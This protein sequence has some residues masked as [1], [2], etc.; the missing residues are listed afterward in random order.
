M[1]ANNKTVN[2]KRGR[3]LPLEFR[4]RTPTL[5]HRA[6]RLVSLD[7]LPWAAVLR[8]RFSM[9]E[10]KSNEEAL[11]HLLFSIGHG[12]KSL[13][14]IVDFFV[15]GHISF[16]GEIIEVPGVRL[17]IQLGYKR[18]FRLSQ[19]VPIYFGK[20]MMLED[21]LNIGKPLGSRIDTPRAG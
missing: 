9:T 7:P 17:R 14:F 13:L 19:R 5:E 18:G 6:K 4:Q 8:G 12:F 15:L 20:I 3:S 16:I 21:I 1:A 10:R 11:A 2:L